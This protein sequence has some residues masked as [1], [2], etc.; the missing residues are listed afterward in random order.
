MLY[1][2]LVVT[3]Q[4]RY[5]ALQIVIFIIITIFS[6]FSLVSYFCTFGQNGIMASALDVVHS[7]GICPML[8]LLLPPL[9]PWL[10][11]TIK[12]NHK[13]SAVVFVLGHHC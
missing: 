13:S 6:Q 10:A 4:T 11:K 1:G 3:L 7:E 2:A 8:P 12:A 5:G 9:I